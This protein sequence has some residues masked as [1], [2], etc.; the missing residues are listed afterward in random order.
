MDE[1]ELAAAKAHHWTKIDTYLEGLAKR[2]LLRRR[3]RLAARSE[4]ESPRLLLGAV[5]F[6]ATMAVLAFLIVCFAVAAW[7]GSQPQFR[8]LPQAREL[9]TAQRGWFEE[10]KKQFR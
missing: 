3:R 8:D 7:P 6:L 10:A 2:T 9:G 4:P 1:P 5:P